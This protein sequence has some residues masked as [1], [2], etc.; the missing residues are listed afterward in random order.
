MME[1]PT[2]LTFKLFLE[3]KSDLDMTVEHELPAEEVKR[4]YPDCSIIQIWKKL[5]NLKL[6]VMAHPF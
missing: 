3:N 2:C 5:H 1:L 6:Y 4:F